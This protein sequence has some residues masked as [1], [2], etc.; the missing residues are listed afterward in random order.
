MGPI[1]AIVKKDILLLLRDRGGLFFV[2]VFPI[3]FALFFASVFSGDGK[4][5]RIGVVVAD[6]DGGD[7]SR[8]F[9]AS[10]VRSDELLVQTVT[11]REE[12][13]GLVRAGKQPA[14]IVIPRGFGEKAGGLFTGDPPRV[15]VGVDPSRKAEG[16]MLKGI[17]LQQA[18]ERMGR[19][20]TDPAMLRSQ[21]ERG[22]EKVRGS[23]AIPEEIRRNLIPLLDRS[24]DLARAIERE[25]EKTPGAAADDSP[26]GDATANIMQPLIIETVDVAKP[27]TGESPP[28]SFSVTYPQGVLWG[29]IGATAGFAISL[30]GERTKGTMVR[31]RAAPIARS[32]VLLGKAGACFVTVVSVV[33][34]LL[35]LARLGYGM[36]VGSPALFALAVMCIGV[37][38]VGVMMLLASLA[39]TEQAAG[40]M[41]W[42]VMIVL[43]M[44]GGGMVPLM[45]MPEWM[46]TL[47][48]VSPV[49]WAIVALEG[50]VWRGYTP[51][52]MVLPCGMLLGVG[53]AGVVVGS[54]VFSRLG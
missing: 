44:I 9:V 20:F 15:E 45:F 16:W 17:L 12:A 2:F 37:C 31:L 40:G 5:S 19:T 39:R 47:S 8:E 48:A 53:V 46:L 43:S 38:F 24:E 26:G 11:G 50:A 6:L 35:A 18:G 34:V 21:A 14:C 41:G 36:R 22:L 32:S 33:L 29:I 7:A 1:L 42:A 13:M 3:M 52:Q 49:K 28:N 10:L 25:R 30:V 4:S 27:R 51:G 54:R 23:S